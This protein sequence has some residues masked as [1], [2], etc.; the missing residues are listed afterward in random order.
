MTKMLSI[1]VVAG[2]ASGDRHAAKLVRALREAEP[3]IAFDFFGA[4][5]PNMRSEGVDPV[6]V[7]DDLGIVGIAEI[8]ASLPVFIR[9]FRS[10]KKMA[11]ERSPDAAI[12]VDF[13][14]F[15]LKLARWLKNKGFTVIYYISPQLWAWR[16]HRVSSVR[17][18]IDLMLT[19]LPFEKEWY[20]RHGV[21]HVEY[22]GSPLAREVRAGTEKAEFCSAHGLDPEKPIQTTAHEPPAQVALAHR[23]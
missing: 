11:V 23:M 10:L 2:E 17:K 21:D 12:L 9:A 16:K 15:N 5:G 18:Y 1:M 13:P 4:A 7:A 6:V 19:I 8:A 22:V 3:Q 14:D 20:Q